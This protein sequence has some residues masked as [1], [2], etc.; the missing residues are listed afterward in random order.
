MAKAQMDAIALLK[1]DHRTVEELFEKYEKARANK[2]DIAKKICLELTV[3]SMLE[4]EIFYPACREA[5]VEEDK[6][7]EAIVEVQ[8]AAVELLR[9]AQLPGLVHRNALIQ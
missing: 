8:G 6:I 9:V 4:E 1:A 5:G 3:H 2:A 7:D